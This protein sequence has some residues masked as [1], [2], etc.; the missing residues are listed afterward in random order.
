MVK[1]IPQQRDMQSH[2]EKNVPFAG[3]NECIYC[4]ISL[5]DSYEIVRDR[6]VA[7]SKGIK[8]K[9]AR[10]RIATVSL[11]PQHGVIKKT[12]SENHWSWWPYAEVDRLTTISG[13]QGVSV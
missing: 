12:G 4:A 13:L 5:F 10:E 7:R 6:L 3:D 2:H 8:A 9:L 1:A 11:N